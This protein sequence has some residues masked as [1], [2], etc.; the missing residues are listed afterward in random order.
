MNTLRHVGRF[1]NTIRNCSLTFG[2]RA[3]A[4]EAARLAMLTALVTVAL[5]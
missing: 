4:S 1:V 5:W 2:C 3:W